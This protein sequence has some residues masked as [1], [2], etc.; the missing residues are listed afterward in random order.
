MLRNVAVGFQNAKG[1]ADLQSQS[2]LLHLPISAQFSFC[3]KQ[4]MQCPRADAIVHLGNCD[5]EL[6]SL[7]RSLTPSFHDD[8]TTNYSSLRSSLDDDYYLAQGCEIRIYDDGLSPCETQ[9]RG[10]GLQTSSWSGE[11]GDIGG[12]KRHLKVCTFTSVTMMKLTVSRRGIPTGLA[13]CK[14]S[15]LSEQSSQA[16]RASATSLGG[17]IPT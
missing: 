8:G 9:V 1:E 14:H 15:H 7:R 11:S 10:E 13:G 3:P 6:G 17:R 5:M 12:F 4:V 2:W 16:Q